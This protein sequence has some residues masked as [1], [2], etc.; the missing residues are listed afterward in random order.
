MIPAIHNIL[1]ATDLSENAH[2][3]FEYASVMADRFGAEIT[4]LHVLE[5]LS[6]SSLGL[7]GEIV[8]KK[9]WADLKRQNEEKII[10]SIRSRIENYYKSLNQTVSKHPSIVQSIIVKTG[11]PVDQI[12]HQAEKTD[13][14]IVVMGSRGHGILTE[15]MLG[16]TSHRV[17]RRCNKPVLVVRLPGNE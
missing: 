5:E 10:S 15:A 7:V 4:I 12:I 6:P 3:A 14:D 11:H 9:R 17:L 1:F 16:S 2:Y 13:C 8:G